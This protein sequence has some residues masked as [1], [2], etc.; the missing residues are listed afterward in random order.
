MTDREPGNEGGIMEVLK[1]ILF[2]LNH[3]TLVL[4]NLQAQSINLI[5]YEERNY[6]EGKEP[7]Y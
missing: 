5:L 7:L 2:T 1:K 6:N 4:G 3:K